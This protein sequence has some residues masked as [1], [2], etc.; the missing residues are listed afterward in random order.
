MG[1]VARARAKAHSKAEL[2]KWGK[3]GGRPGKL[4]LKVVTLLLQRLVL[5]PAVR[6][7]HAARLDRVL[8]EGNQTGGR[9]VAD[10]TAA[11]KSEPWQC[12]V[13]GRSEPWL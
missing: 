8:D 9:G 6:V 10:L 13:D 2:R 11:W 12:L 1:G 3:R 4:D 5:Q 7:E